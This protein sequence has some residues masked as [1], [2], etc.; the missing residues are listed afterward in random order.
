[1]PR[2][3]YPVRPPAYQPG[4]EITSQQLNAMVAELDRLRAEVN[5]LATLVGQLMADRYALAM[6]TATGRPG[7]FRGAR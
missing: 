4:S 5:L 3:D 7:L 1:M 2:P 6:H